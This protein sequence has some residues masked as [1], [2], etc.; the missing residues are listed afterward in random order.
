MS[1][2]LTVAE[3][4]QHIRLLFDSDELLRMCFVK[5]E[6]SGVSLY[7]SGHLY[8]TLKDSSHQ[9]ACVMFRQEHQGLKFKLKEGMKVTAAGRVSIFSGRSQYQLIVQDLNP[10]GVGELYLAFLELKEKL[11]KEGL[12]DPAR[13]RPIP[14]FPKTVGIVTSLQGAALHDMISIIQRRNS[15][16]QILISPSPVQGQDAPGN[17][18]AALKRLQSF[19]DVEVILLARGGGSLEDLWSFNDE[20]LAREIFQCRVPVISGVGHETDFTIADFAADKRAPTPSAAAELISPLQKDLQQQL[21][22]LA[23]RLNRSMERKIQEKEL[24]RLDYLQQQL[25][26]AYQNKLKISAMKLDSLREK[27]EALSPY[28]ILNRGYV[29]VTAAGKTI[30]TAEKALEKKRGTL[31]F[32]DG[33]V[34][35]LFQKSSSEKNSRQQFVQGNFFS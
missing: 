35:A 20:N 5:G 7:P 33:T 24:Q 13:K 19:P 11:E 4:C 23:Q 21:M 27:L 28:G 8:F 6:V 12:F 32:A 18:I 29:L 15:A 30:K 17:L 22:Q 1:G 34:E 26:R 16:I 9:I 10:D 31:I 3:L 25:D 2:V 14:F